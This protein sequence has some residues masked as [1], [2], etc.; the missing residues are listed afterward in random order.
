MKYFFDTEFIE[1]GTT[2]DLL[3]IG[4]IAE[5][6][7]EYYRQNIE[8]NFAAA[9]DWMLRNVMPHLQ[10]YNMQGF[11]TC[12]ELSKLGGMGSRESFCGPECPWRR[13]YEIRDEVKAF[14]DIEK[15][16]KPEIW[17]YYADYDWVAFCQLFGKMI[18]L[19]KGF[20]MWCRDLKQ[21]CDQL[22]NPPLTEQGKGEH[23]AL[24]DAKWNAMVYRDLITLQNSTP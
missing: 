6:G 20:P 4:L 7:R 8:C 22:G 9:G 18:D 10:H 12:N 2:I 5:D 23:H 24:A 1:N 11:R 16:G 21:L 15:F 19:P 3:S 14:L 17:G 13:K